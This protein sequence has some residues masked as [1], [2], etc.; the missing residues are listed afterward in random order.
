[1]SCLSSPAPPCVTSGRP[2]AHAR[3]RHGARTFLAPTTTSRTNVGTRERERYW[4]CGKVCFTVWFHLFLPTPFIV[5]ALPR[6][7][8]ASQYPSSYVPPP[9]AI[10]PGHRPCT[11]LPC[12]RRCVPSRHVP[13]DTI[14]RRPLRARCP[15]SSAHSLCAPSH[16]HTI[17]SCRRHC[18]PPGRCLHI[19]PAQEF[20]GHFVL[21]DHLCSHWGDRRFQPTHERYA[22]WSPWLS[23]VVLPSVDSVP[24]ALSLGVVVCALCF[25]IVPY[26]YCIY[27]H[28]RTNIPHSQCDKPVVIKIT[29]DKKVRTTHADMSVCTMCRYT[30]V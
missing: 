13:P 6:P 3:R 10:V 2:I 4:E 30:Q 11:S 1:M 26:H 24:L 16:L 27:L 22:L 23:P 14:Q 8:N 18:I 21:C 25:V 15:T 29:R 19:S 12:C 7:L 28:S 5:C 20:P 9:F 17:V